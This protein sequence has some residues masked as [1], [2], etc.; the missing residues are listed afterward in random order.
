M[1]D[2]PNYSRLPFVIR[3][4]TSAA[5][6]T[7]L[8]AG[9]AS[10]TSITYTYADAGVYATCGEGS[11][12]P[13][14]SESST[15]SANCGGASVFTLAQAFVQNGHLGALATGDTSISNNP[16]VYP[17][18]LGHAGAEA[19][20]DDV[21]T[22][23]SGGTFLLE[24][25]A[26]GNAS[27]DPCDSSGGNI[28]NEVAARVVL[29][30]P[31]GNYFFDDHAYASCT[32]GALV[33]SINSNLNLAAGAVLTLSASVDAVITVQAYAA[34]MTDSQQSDI[35]HSLFFYLTPLTPGASYSA[36]S[37]ND[38]V[39][40]ADTAPVPEPATLT[41]TALGLAGVVTRYNRR[42]SRS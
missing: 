33:Q 36:A 27:G 4:V 20:L 15:A 16:A 2:S 40:P 29:S 11:V 5:A 22:V 39:R 38:Y 42:R 12:I 6:L 23:Q 7:I 37:G 34:G 9:R 19:T 21:L 41:L 30:A 17:L 1:I 28:N 18:T 3:A 13:T 14:V 8:T 31:T 10:A 25:F 32:S 24:A 26:V 35:G